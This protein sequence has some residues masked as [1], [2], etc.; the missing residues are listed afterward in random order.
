M[1][2]R[3]KSPSKN[4]S[5]APRFVKL[6]AQSNELDISAKDWVQVLDKETNLIW[7][8]EA[9]DDRKTFTEA[10]AYAESL[11]LAGAFWRVP[12][13]TELLSLVD[14]ERSDPAINTDFFTCKSN[15]HW[16]STVAAASPSVY[17][18][19]VRF[20]YG[21]SYCIY[22]LNGAFVRAVRSAGQ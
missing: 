8:K 13:I 5:S 18:W 22:Q 1:A 20:A 12:T 6:D 15:W 21:G 19:Y 9:S 14:Y 2:T 3:K 7:A 4:I 16:S 11:K 10:K 17:A